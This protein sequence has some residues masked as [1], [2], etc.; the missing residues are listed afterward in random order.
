MEVLE[1][2]GAWEKAGEEGAAQWSGQGRMEDPRA[3]SLWSVLRLS[4]VLYGESWDGG[5]Q[6][7][8]L[9]HCAKMLSCS[10]L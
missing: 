6:R 9:P 5:K 7:H 3:G 10:V 4:L 1:R 8:P 2:V